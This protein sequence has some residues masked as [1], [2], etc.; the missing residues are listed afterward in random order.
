MAKDL[1]LGIDIGTSGC[2][3]ALFYRDG[4]SICTVTEEYPVYYPKP[5]YVEQDPEDWWNAVCRGTKK[6]ILEN[7]IDPADI[8]GVGIDGQSWAAIAVDDK[9][10]RCSRATPYGWI[11]VRM[12]YASSLIKRSARKKYLPYRE[13]R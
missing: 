11:R 12:R 13:I 7:S 9:R 5:G 6:I 2:K 1:L 4:K 8:A 10:A 3:I